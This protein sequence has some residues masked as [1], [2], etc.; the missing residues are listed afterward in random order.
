M[1]VCLT[2]NETFVKRNIIDVSKWRKQIQFPGFEQIIR[3]F[4][5]Y[6]SGCYFYDDLQKFFIFPH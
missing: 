2:V 1:F 5:Q 4:N 6:K 3:R